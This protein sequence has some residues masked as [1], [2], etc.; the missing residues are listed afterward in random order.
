MRIGLHCCRHFKVKGLMYLSFFELMIILS[1]IL[2][3]SGNVEPNPGPEFS[4]Y[5]SA[6]F[7]SSSSFSSSN[8]IFHEHFSVVH[9]NIQSLLNKIDILESELKSFDVGC[10]SETWLDHRTADND[11][12]RHDFKVHYRRDRQDDNHGGICVYAKEN[13]SAKRRVD[14][15]LQDIECLWIEVSSNRNKLLIGTFYK[16]PNSPPSTQES[17]E[18]PIGLAYDTNIDKILITGGLD[19]DTLKSAHS[20][21]IEILC[22]NLNQPNLI[23]EP[24]HF[25]E[26]SASIIDLMLTSNRH[27]V[28]LSGTDVSCLEQTVRYHCP[29][30]RVSHFKEAITKV[31]SRQVWFYDRGE[32][33]AFREKNPNF[34]WQSLKHKYIDTY[35]KN[36]TDFSLTLLRSIFQKKL[37][38]LESPILS[39]IEQ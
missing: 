24:T 14:L 34:D 31:F 29:T 25:T 36:V 18:N 6:S 32:Y 37:Y 4:D 28:L 9:Y 23:N 27:G 33:D 7:S 39:M 3:R 2:L 5:D 16:P 13:V 1:L 21:K 10:L 8:T 30:F 38:G 17:I 26:S 15:E 11:I 22:Q 20:R 35:T 19:L 12:N